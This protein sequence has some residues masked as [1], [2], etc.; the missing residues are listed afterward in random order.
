MCVET[1]VSFINNLDVNGSNICQ[2]ISEFIPVQGFTFIEIINWKYLQCSLMSYTEFPQNKDYK[3]FRVHDSISLGVEN[4]V[5][6]C[7]WYWGS[8]NRLSQTFHECHLEQN[9]Y[10]YAYMSQN[11]NIL[12]WEKCKKKWDCLFMG[13]EEVCVSF[14]NSTDFSKINT[15]QCTHTSHLL[16]ALLHKL[17]SSVWVH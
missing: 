3:L 10:T 7:I 11:R 1:F 12:F 13:I 14:I 9:K 8:S 17:D 5:F 15:Q 16:P 2:Q 6:L 4:W